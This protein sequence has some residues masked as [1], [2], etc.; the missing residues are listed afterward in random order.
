MFS[1]LD[2]IIFYYL[3]YFRK[4]VKEIFKKLKRKNVVKMDESEF[5]F[6]LTRHG[7]EDNDGLVEL[8]QE[9]GL[10]QGIMLFN[11]LADTPP[12]GL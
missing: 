4:N 8:D 11:I 1:L 5:S 9:D 7:L 6:D 12:R 10:I 2:K 3:T